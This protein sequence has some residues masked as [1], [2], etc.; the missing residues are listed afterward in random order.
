[1]RQTQ[2]IALTA[3]FAALHTIL[4]LIPGPVGFR[5]WIILIMP[6]EGI[7]LGPAMG[8]SAGFIGYSLGWFIRPRAE[9][10]FF[11][12]GEPIGAL[13]AGLIAQR[14]W[15]YALFFYSVMLLA[16]FIYP[17]TAT[18][19]L[20]TLWDIY[21]AFICILLFAFLS[22]TM[23]LE[24]SHIQNLPVLLGFSAFI[25]TEADI[26][27]RITMLVPLNGYQWWGVQASILPS[28][29][30]LGAFQ[31]PTEAVISVI[32]TIIIGV[33][34]VKILQKNRVS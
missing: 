21:A 22:K 3:V 12:L 28:I 33:P 14:K 7:L 23:K 17:L 1:L 4:S 31:T 30:V 32:A 24:K 18:L 11:G 15:S 34:L 27:T 29:F 2:K 19:P 25:G 6:L 13:T 10:I 9:P 26:L 16:F 5:S 8:F 20:W